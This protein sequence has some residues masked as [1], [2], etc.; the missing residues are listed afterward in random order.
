MLTRVLGYPFG[1]EIG[2]LLHVV[3]LGVDG[4]WRVYH[5]LLYS[6][7]VVRHGGN[8]C[9]LLDVGVHCGAGIRVLKSMFV[10]RIRGNNTFS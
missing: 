3:C 7:V 8:T 1:E 6:G 4:L 10:D 2:V 9:C 5:L